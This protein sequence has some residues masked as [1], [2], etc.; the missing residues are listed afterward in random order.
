MDLT[1]RQLLAGVTGELALLG[2][3]K[4]VDNVFLGYG[5]FTGTNLLQQDLAPLVTERLAPSGPQ[6]ATVDGYRIEHRAGRFVVFDPAEDGYGRVAALDPE[7]ADR[8]DAAAVDADLD[9]PGAPLEQLVADARALERGDVRVAAE[10]YPAF[11]DLLSSQSTRP[12]SVAAVRGRRVEDVDSD[13]VETFTGVS[14]ADT[15]A[16]VEGLADGFREHA[17]YDVPRYLAGSVEDNVLFGARDLRRRFESP[18]DFEA[19]LSGDSDGLFCT[20]MTYRAMEAMH[21]VPA[22]EQTAPT[23]A[24]YVFDRRHKHV[25]LLLA[26]VVRDDGDLVI[27]T[28]FVDYM[29]ATLYDDFRLDGL[30]GDEIDAYGDDYRAD[31]VY[32]RG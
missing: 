19:I 13:V 8:E 15:R 24:G 16:L 17:T 30:L 25:Y 27:P 5:R 18:T 11:F 10:S 6:V 14:P 26:S 1:R 3:A 28:T 2:G 22:P 7:S 23:V 4:A 9:L 20:E 29:Y 12:Y 31:D 32:W 21:A